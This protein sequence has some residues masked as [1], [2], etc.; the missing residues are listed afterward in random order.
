MQRKP[1]QDLTQGPVARS[2]FRLTAPMMLAVSSSIIVQ[3]IEIG[4]IGQLGTAQIA[5]VTFTFPITMML[6]SVAMGISIGTSSVIARRVGGGDWDDVRRFATH[7]LLLVALLLTVLAAIGAATIAPT[8][9]ALGAHGAVLDHI[10]GYLLIYYPGTVLFTVTIV[11]GSTM[12]A[13]GDA[14]IPG[15]IMTGGAMLNL[16]LDP[17]LIFGWFGAPRLEL[18]GAAAAMVLSRLVM[19][20]LLFYFAIAKDR[21]FLPIRQWRHNV[22]ASWREVLVVGIPAMAT[23]MIGPISGAII[24]R[25][26][27]SHGHDVV[28]GFGVAGR[29]EGVAVMLLF[30]LSGSIGPFVGQNWG[31]GD[32]DRVRAGMR[33]AYRFSVGWGAFAWLVL[34][35]LG[36]RL[37]PLIDSNPEVIST[38][39]HY[40]AIVPISYGLW[41]VLM[42]ASAAFNSLGKPIPSTVMAF[43]R[44]FILYVPLAMLADHLFGYTGIF[45]ATATANCV[46]GCWGYVWLKRALFASA[47]GSLVPA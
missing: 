46:M 25:L 40:L 13:T 24:T 33:V 38:A 23:Q 42:M 30:A 10:R 18:A 34:L 3:M 26:L 14:R 15:L 27:A 19:T 17:I 9:S 8:F 1:G 12:R 47:R 32:L 36:D 44:M 45:V 20:G 31:A 29:I 2:L 41:G 4:F 5:A 43:T 11:T 6:T 28:A 37:V 7:S 35:V 21:L 22:L 16:A 39:R